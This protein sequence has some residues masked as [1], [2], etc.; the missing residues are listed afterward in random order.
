M[1]GFLEVAAG[2]C[3]WREFML[4]DMTPQ[5]MALMTFHSLT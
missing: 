2:L 5:E 4:L 3:L 1:H